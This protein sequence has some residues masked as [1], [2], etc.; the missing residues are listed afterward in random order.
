VLGSGSAN[1]ENNVTSAPLTAGKTV[2]AVTLPPGGT[3]PASGRI[4]G[5]HIF[6]LGIG[7]LNAEGQ[8]VT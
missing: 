2:Q 5:M 1:A 6:G 4:S 7:P 8:P 3:V